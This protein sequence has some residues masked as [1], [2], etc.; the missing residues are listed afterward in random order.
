MN[1]QLVISN[2]SKELFIQNIKQ[3]VYFDTKIQQFNENI[4]LAK[5]GKDQASGCIE[6]YFQQNPSLKDCVEISNGK[7]S[8]REKK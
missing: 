1:N 6:H 5:I 8:V 3:W 4:R 2:P 7:V